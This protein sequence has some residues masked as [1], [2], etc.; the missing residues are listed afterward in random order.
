[1]KAPVESAPLRRGKSGGTA[2]ALPPMAW[3][4]SLGRLWSDVRRHPALTVFVGGYAAIFLGAWWCHFF[5]PSA[6]KPVVEI[7]QSAPDEEPPGTE[8]LV[9]DIDLRQPLLSPR[10]GAIFGTDSSGANVLTRIVRGAAETLSAALV[11]SV[12]A[13]GL[14]FCMVFFVGWIAGQ[15]GYELLAAAWSGF[16]YLPVVVIAWWLSAALEP[17]FGSVVAVIAI[18]G[19]AVVVAGL[20]RAFAKT[21]DAAHVIAAR[22]A[23]F[24]RFALL[25][26]EVVPFVSQRLVSY[27]AMLLP[28]AVLLETALSFVGFGLGK[29]SINNWGLMIAEGQALMFEAP[30]LLIAPGLV[31]A[32]TVGWLSLTA[33]SIRRV[34]KEKDFLSMV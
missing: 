31:I 18:S 10:A 23:G 8:M 24:S 20:A 17:S 27:G 13:V 34:T 28:G 25:R 3:W 11:G 12:I 30:W 19:S 1:M 5:L 15:R 9:T 2:D 22:A 14:G 26:S 4:Q 33:R 32:V 29:S 7:A 21:E 16:R 6:T